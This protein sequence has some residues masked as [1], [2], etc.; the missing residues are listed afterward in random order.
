MIELDKAYDHTKVED[1][2]YKQWEDSGY[3]TPESLPNA[4]A[5]QPF[6]IILPPPNATGTLHIGH[7]FEDT[8]QDI[9]IRFQ[10]M[11]G[12]R[13]L[14]LP[15]TDH[16]AIATNTKV[17][18]ELIKKEGKNR[19][20]IGREAFIKLVEDFVQG[21]RGIIQKQMRRMGASVDWSREAFTMDDNRKL[22]VKKAFQELYQAGLIYI[23]ERIVNWDPKG[24]TTVSDDEVVYKA[25]KGQLYY[26]KYSKDFPITIATTRPETKVGDTA[27]A[28]N[29]QDTRYKQYIG[30]EY[31]AEFAGTNLHIKIVS[32]ETVDPEFGTGAVGV[33]PAHSIVDNEIAQRHKLPSVQVINE[34]AK[35]MDSAGTLVAG[36]KTKEAREIVVQWL[37]ENNLLEKT[38]TIDQNIST[39]E[40]SGGIIEPLPKRHQWF[41]AVEKQF[42][43]Q[44]SKI[45]GIK[46]GDS[47]T[48]KRLMRQVVKNG[49]I[50]ILPERFEKIYFHWID[51]LRDWNISRQLWYGHPIPAQYRYLTGEYGE[52]EVRLGDY[53]EQDGWKNFEDTLDTWFSSALWTF[54]T[55]G[56]PNQAKDLETY[57]PTSVMMPGY[58][59]LFFWVARMILMSTSLLGE[60]PFQQVVL[61]GI[62]RDSKGQKFSKSL[63][64]GID[65]LDMSNKYGTDALR[66]ALV[67]GAAPGN[68][69]IF[70]EQKVK[71]MKNFAN[72]LWNISR[73]VLMN[74]SES[75]FKWEAKTDADK[76][77]L[78]KLESLIKT[79]TDHLE[80]FRLHEAAQG[81]YQF[82]WHEFADIYIEASKPQLQD[83]AT[84]ENTQKI[85]LHIL[86]S[87]L[88]MLHPFM[89]FVTEEIWTKMREAKLLKSDDLLIVSSWPK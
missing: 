51:N 41:I 58:E 8:I 36:K 31:D 69:V 62:V 50:K 75:D 82:T 16:A 27:V 25:E 77:I 84:K 22:A 71:G 64:N 61:H 2:I 15:G 89:P 20:D 86:I 17:E 35:M 70:D 46:S 63:D 9:I 78:T 47:I 34:Y 43:I 29:P 49:Q 39:A 73:Y 5:R 7:A 26:F 33:T 54:S 59:I 38:E 88:K 83:E 14:W 6:T 68:D 80:N 42:T 79:S 4:E 57:H 52:I 81:T 18:K 44:H 48:L 23:G 10:R 76:D 13:T 37:N 11:Q 56:W 19:H 40:R 66:M 30:K 67:F 32:D 21:S 72:K 45:N 12:K 24:Q 87:T 60:V 55:L 28:V 3:F 65:P 74:V 53:P 1:K 85:L